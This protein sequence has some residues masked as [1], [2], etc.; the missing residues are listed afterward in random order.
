MPSPD[1]LRPFWHPVAR[2]D[3]VMPGPVGVTLLDEDLVLWR[4]DGQVHAARDLCVHRGSRLSLGWVDAAGCVVCP[5]HGWRYDGAGTCVFIPSQPADDQRIPSRARTPAYRTV[6]RYG[7][8]WVA[9]D[10]PVDDLP[11]FPQFDDPAFRTF[12]VGRFEWRAGADRFVENAIDVAHLPFV[13]PGL[14][15]DP[16]RPVIAPYEIRD[17]GAGF[18]FANERYDVDAS[19]F[20]TKGEMICRETWVRMPFSWR[21]LI[22]S[23]RGRLATFLAVQPVSSDRCRFWPLVARTYALDV[24]DQEFGDFDVQVIEQDRVVVESQRPEM[25]PVDLTAEL[26]VKVAD[27]ASIE[28]RRRLREIAARGGISGRTD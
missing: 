19:Q 24:S 26:H 1:H 13:H 25:L 4:A 12:C 2:G 10:D 8:V 27:A 16:E 21:I 5:Y 7:L 9:L 6:E 15:G 3:D 23:R 22:Q 20:G 17:E 28:Y 11:P 18:Y 14:L